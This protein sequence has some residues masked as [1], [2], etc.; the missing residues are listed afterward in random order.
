MTNQQNTIPAHV[1]NFLG[2]VQGV[3][4]GVAM[5][6]SNH[7]NPDEA[8]MELF[9]EAQ[10]ILFPPPAEPVVEDT[11]R[12]TSNEDYRIAGDFYRDD[13][14]I[15]PHKDTRHGGDQMINYFI[16]GMRHE[17]KRNDTYRV[18]WFEGT[19][20][21]NEI[22]SDEDKLRATIAALDYLLTKDISSN[23]AYRRLCSLRRDISAPD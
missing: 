8:L 13:Y 18:V 12:N 16:A 22:A 15:E 10:T 7:P 5:S 6:G 17:R 9:T 11:E 1:R 2:K 20:D 14:G 23:L 4:M 3:C 19:K 21:F